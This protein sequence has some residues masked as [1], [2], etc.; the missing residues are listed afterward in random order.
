MYYNNNP[1]EWSDCV[2]LCMWL[3]TWNSLYFEQN[4]YGR[5]FHS[6][7]W[8]Q[9]ANNTFNLQQ[10]AKWKQ[11]NCSIGNRINRRQS[12]VAYS[13]IY[14]GLSELGQPRNCVQWISLS[15]KTTWKSITVWHRILKVCLGLCCSGLGHKIKCKFLSSL[16]HEVIRDS[17]TQTM[18]NGLHCFIEQSG[19]V[20]ACWAH[21]PEVR[22]SKPRSASLFFFF[23]FF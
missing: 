16:T 2:T 6:Q 19:A 13:A 10:L 23:N 21:N 9:D 18:A 15:V 22:G 20:E 3:M 11:A 8:T 7:C 5:L 1:V 17:V 12:F 14:R 4:L